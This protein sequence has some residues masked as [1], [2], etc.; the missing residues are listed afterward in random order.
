MKSYF[1]ITFLLLY[2]ILITVIVSPIAAGILPFHL[3]RIMSRMVL[4]TSILLFVY[5]KDKF[6]IPN[7]KS[8]GFEFNKRWW[9]LL[10][11][12]YVLGLL[13]MGIISGLM[14][15]GSIRYIVPD[16][17]FMD[18]ARYSLVCLLAGLIVA[19]FEE[20]IFRGF[21]FQ[22]L[23]K[24]SRIV[25][26]IFLTN[27]LYSTVHFMRPSVY[28]NITTLSFINSVNSVSAFFYPL[29][30]EFYKIWP[31]AIGLFLVG[32]ALSLAYLRA[33]TLALPIGIHAAWIFGIKS[34]SHGT[35]V[36]VSG[37]LW[38]S[39]NVLAN[40]FTWIVLIIFSLILVISRHEVKR[41]V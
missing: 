3:Y 21:I 22:S 8:M 24:D 16:T 20:C 41:M 34:L 12:G 14:L 39:G 23:L 5:Y 28:G 33:R 13:T 27:I 40:P 29:Y 9:L 32:M 25:F 2:A 7:I 17:G 37:S 35:D 26:S 4:I 31:T 1:K 19:F 18:L 38:V 30:T 11:L 10:C 15:Y 6:G 36:S